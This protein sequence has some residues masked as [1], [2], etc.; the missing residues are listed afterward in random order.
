MEKLVKKAYGKINLG[1]DVLRRRPDGY[2]DVKMI[3][4]TVDIYDELTFV[5]RDDDKIVITTDKAELPCDENN[6]I[7]KAAMRIFEYK[8]SKKGVSI[9]LNKHIPVAAGMAGGS[10]DAAATLLA[11]NELFELGLSTDELLKI[12]VTIGADVPYC[13][14][15]GTALSEGI[16]EVLTPLK[17]PPHCKLVIAKPDINVSTKYVYENLNLAG[18][19]RHPDI[20]G[21]KEAIENEDLEGISS[22]LENVLESVTVKKYGI[23][24]QIKEEMLKQGAMNAVMSGSGPTVF[25]LFESEEKAQLTKEAILQKGYAKEV[26]VST[27]YPNS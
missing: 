23:I 27:F 8:G 2:H 6:L 26:F 25:G 1:L 4:Q 21:M 18:L 22:R 13:I 9:H 12:G 15:G 14:I 20:D 16:G 11:V 24:E 7:Y 17:N 5:K 19:L 3:M 10:T